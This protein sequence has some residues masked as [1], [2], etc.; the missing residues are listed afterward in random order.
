MEALITDSKK[1]PAAEQEILIKATLCSYKS[2][3]T[4]EVSL[5]LEDPSKTVRIG[6]NLDP[7]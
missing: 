3:D 2:R 5:G 6:A 7:K 1:I 4:K